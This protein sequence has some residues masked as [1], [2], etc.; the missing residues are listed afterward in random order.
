[1][2]PVAGNGSAGNPIDFVEP[3]TAALE[4]PGHIT[5]DSYGS[6][7][8]VQPD[9]D[10]VRKIGMGFMWTDPVH[11]PMSPLATSYNSAC[12]IDNFGTNAFVFLTQCNTS[13]ASFV[14]VEQDGTQNTLG[15]EKLPPS[16]PWATSTDVSG[17]ESGETFFVKANKTIVKLDSFGNATQSWATIGTSQP[18]STITFDKSGNVGGLIVTTKLGEIFRIDSF[19][20]VLSVPVPSEY[21]LTGPRAR[22]NVTSLVS[23]P[24]DASIFG[25]FAGK[26]LISA[27]NTKVS[28]STL[29]IVNASGQIE[30]ELPA[31]VA[32]VDLDV[33]SYVPHNLFGISTKRAQVYGV[34]SA[35][36]RNAG[37]YN[38]IFGTATNG[39]MYK[40][41][42]PTGQRDIRITRIEGSHQGLTV[43]VVD[44]AFGLAGISPIE[45]AS[46]YITVNPADTLMFSSLLLSFVI[47]VLILN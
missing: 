9:L 33:A 13:S 21:R 3:L 39:H 1:V 7:Y 30:T 10:M 18:I 17:F 23:V 31:P 6:L 15:N 27:R 11:I 8:I 25:N 24:N 34:D 44:T 40:F 47:L 46:Y 32:F 41:S 4:S 26:V 28:F 29:L 38:C 45:Q 16:A 5:F 12:G 2:I 43:S 19:G 37:I 22:L 14:T 20:S 36:V 42:W 35:T